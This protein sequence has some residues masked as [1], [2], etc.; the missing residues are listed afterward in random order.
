[1]LIQPFRF[2]HESRKCHDAIYPVCR[3]CLY[4]LNRKGRVLCGEIHHRHWPLQT[5]K[6]E[7]EQ[8]DMT[9]LIGIDL[10]D[11]PTH[12]HFAKRLDVV[13]WRNQTFTLSKI[14]LSTF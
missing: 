5:A 7:I 12:I 9:Q 4:T 14:A 6:V 2:G 3:Y 10:V 13:A 8:L 1:M 11:E